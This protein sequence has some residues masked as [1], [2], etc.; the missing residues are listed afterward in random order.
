MAPDTRRKG[1]VLAGLLV[2]LAA[3]LWWNLTG[4]DGPALP[5]GGGRRTPAQT[6][7]RAEPV[8]DVALEALEAARPQPEESGRDP[9]RFGRGRRSG[10]AVRED[11]DEPGGGGSGTPPTGAAAPSVPP[12][13]PGP[14]PIALKFIGIVDETAKQTKLAV[15]SDGRNVYY[16]REGDI[17]EGRYRIVRIGVESIEMAHADGRG[18]QTIRLSGS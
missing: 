9:F 2:V 15:L 7:A 1:F 14:P 3:V 4:G 17:I 5:L 6:P 10:G 12:A 11:E 18:R 13:P 8:Q 16:G